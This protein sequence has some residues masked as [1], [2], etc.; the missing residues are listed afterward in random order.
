MSTLRKPINL[1]FLTQVV[2]VFLVAFGIWPRTL[3]ILLAAL[4]AFF[5]LWKDLETSTAFFI[6]SVP[7]FV[8]IPFTSYFD[9]FNIWRVASGLIFLKWFFKWYVEKRPETESGHHD[10]FAKSAWYVPI[11]LLRFIKNYPLASLLLL[12]LLL[13]ILS[14]LVA[15]DLFSGI[16]RII[17]LLN[18][19]MVPLVIYDLIKKNPGL[20]KKF[21]GSILI[22][23]AIA[24][25]IGLA[26]LISAYLMPLGAF[27]EFWGNTMQLGFYGY[28]WASTALEVNTWFAYF[29]DQLS[30]RVFSIFPDSHS[31]PVYLLMTIP[32]LL[33]KRF[34][35]GS[36]KRSALGLIFLL[37][38]FY[39]LA[40]LSGT[41]GIWLAVLAPLLALPFLFRYSQTKE[42]KIILKR[43][44]LLILPFFVLFIA[45]FPIMGS[46]QFWV[47]KENN[48]ILAKRIRSI[49]DL[50]ETSNSGRVEIWKK[51]VQSIIKHPLLG[52]GIGNYPT[53]LSQHPD[54]AKAGSSAHNLYLNIAAEIGVVG[55]LASLGILGIIL[56]RAWILFV[57]N[58]PYTHS[59]IPKEIL[60]GLKHRPRNFS[61]QR[62]V[63]GREWVGMADWPFLKIYSAAFILYSLW[64]LFYSL[65]DA[66]LFD[67]RAFLIFAINSAIIL[68][69]YPTH[70]QQLPLA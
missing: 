1:V 38:F 32:A 14:L 48:E 22:S 30:L 51:T 65:T 59:K 33:A 11:K 37:L 23:G 67:E 25:G 61:L 68:G 70:N 20:T 42:G 2:V 58:Q 17:Y 43:I 4:I 6:R 7:L 21:L 60:V 69:L 8:A 39:L 41:R 28:Q 64:V 50:N 27:I 13:S 54:L 9:S 26:Q 49:L 63:E 24:A 53:V 66:I 52:V 3:I 35:L 44:G 10:T 19:S 15:Q 34:D 46:N 55:L 16:K 57:A 45:A 5:V 47:E 36:S 18:L 40:I 62:K 56:R 29:G 31:F 12:F